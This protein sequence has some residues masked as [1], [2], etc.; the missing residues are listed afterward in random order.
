[1]TTPPIKITLDPEKYARLLANAEAICQQAGI[2]RW[3]LETSATGILSDQEIEWL[4]NYRVHAKQGRGYVL[5]GTHEG[6]SPETRFSA[7]TAAFLRN[8]IDA[9]VSTI[10]MVLAAL[11]GTADPDILECTVL[12]LPNFSVKQ[13]GGKQMPAWKLQSI[14]DY[15]L[16]R[17]SQ[18]KPTVLYV[19]DW[20]MMQTEFGVSIARHLHENFLRIES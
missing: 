19:E 9:R 11:E 2:P 3:R 17:H 6:Y 1:M 10:N 15:L 4:K 5:V 14:H 8:Y 7:L 16:L 20:T 13:N 12:C 18:S